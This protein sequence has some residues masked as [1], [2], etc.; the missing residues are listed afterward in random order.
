[1]ITQCLAYSDISSV[2]PGANL[3][4]SSEVIR[5]LSWPKPALSMAEPLTRQHDAHLQNEYASTCVATSVQA[6]FATCWARREIS[7]CPRGNL[8]SSLK[9]DH[10]PV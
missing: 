1:M 8:I 10:L 3:L 4:T 7:Y 6:Q 9:Y 5:Q 2:V